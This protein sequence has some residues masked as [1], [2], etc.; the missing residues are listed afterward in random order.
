MRSIKNYRIKI[1]QFGLVSLLIGSMSGWRIHSVA[2]TPQKTLEAESSVFVSVTGSDR[3]LERSINGEVKQKSTLIHNFTN[4]NHVESL[5]VVT[6][7]LL[8]EVENQRSA[9]PWLGKH[10][11]FAISNS[12]GNNRNA[13]IVSPPR[14]ITTDTG[15][16]IANSLTGPGADVE[17][18]LQWFADFAVPLGTP[19]LVVHQQQLLRPRIVEALGWVVKANGNVVLTTE[20]EHVTIQAGW[21]ILLNCQQLSISSSS[22]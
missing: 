13:Y 8:V 10:K 21:W 5:P 1:Y 11:I 22:H 17:N 15:N 7:T 6:K 12:E 16:A 2:Q 4:F 18:N 3:L 14:F 19:A 9:Y 20:P